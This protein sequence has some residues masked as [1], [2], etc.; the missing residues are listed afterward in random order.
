MLERIDHRAVVGAM[1]G[2][3][4]DDVARK[5]EMVAQR[6]QLLLRRIAGRVFALRHIGKFGAGAE[7]MAMCVDGAGRHLEAGF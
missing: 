2:R 5:T 6:K 1:T 4:H 7:H 3:L